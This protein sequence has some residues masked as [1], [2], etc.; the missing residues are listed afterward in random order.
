MK[1]L[2]IKWQD[3]IYK[4]WA[5]KDGKNLWIHY[6]GHTWLW[7]EKNTSLKSHALKEEKP[8]NGLILSSMPGRIDKIF[9]KKGDKVQKDQV[10]LVMSAMKIEYSFTAEASGKV[11]EVYCNK[12]DTV[13]VQQKLMKVKYVSD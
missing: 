3:K 4:F 8:L 6:K 12:G 9:Y 7:N 10:L 13:E 1:F 2:E 11:E 5:Q